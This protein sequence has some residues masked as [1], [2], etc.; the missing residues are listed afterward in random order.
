MVSGKKYNGLYTDIW[1]CGI[2]LY[3][4]ICGF[5]P[6]E[7]SNTHILYTKI[8]SSELKVPSFISEIG[9]SLLKGILNKIPEKRYTIQ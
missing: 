3:A 4:M 8:M 7:D 6:F 2:I 5:L 1:S 9:K